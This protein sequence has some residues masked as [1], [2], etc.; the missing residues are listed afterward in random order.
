MRGRAHKEDVKG[1]VVAA[2]LTGHSV[3]E[4]AKLLELPHSSV[5]DIRSRLT[6]EQFVELRRKKGE[7][8]EE[9]V[10]TYLVK[11]LEGLLVQVAVA[12]DEEYLR[13]Q[14][15]G[16]LATLMGVLSDKLL[17]ILDAAERARASEPIQQLAA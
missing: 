12:S 4:T 3:T 14:P 7:R 15:A 13:K 9:L 6:D 10:Y 16:E 1:Q 11:G 8:V 17:R 5:S 2:L